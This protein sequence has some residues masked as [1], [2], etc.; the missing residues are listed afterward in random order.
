MMNVVKVLKAL[1][2]LPLRRRTRAVNAAI[3]D[4]A[5]FIL[6]HRLF[7]SS[8]H[9]AR[10]ANRDW[11]DLRFPRMWDTDLLEMLEV[12]TGLGIRDQRMQDALEALLARRDNQGRWAL[13]KTFNGRYVV[14][15][16]KKGRPSR[17]VTLKA[18]TVLR[19]WE[20]SA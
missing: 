12:L 16:E 14:S 4:C 11:L 7:R 17:W 5:E 8:S 19:R 10:V 20:E 3:G 13:D 18:L 2:A 6:S 9:P 1:S 15:I